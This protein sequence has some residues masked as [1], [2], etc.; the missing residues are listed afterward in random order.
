MQ[1]LACRVILLSTFW[2]TSILLSRA[3]ASV[4]V[5]HVFS[6]ETVVTAIRFYAEIKNGLHKCILIPSKILHNVCLVKS[7]SQ[8]SIPNSMLSFCYKYT[9]TYY[10]TEKMY[11]SL[12]WQYRWFI[13]SFDLLYA[14]S[15]LCFKCFLMF[16]YFR[17]RERQRGNKGG[18]EREGDTESQAGSRHWAISTE[19]KAGLK[20]TNE[21][22][23]RDL[24]WSQTLNQRSHPGA[25]MIWA[26][27]VNIHI[28]FLKS[29]I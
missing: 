23:D 10:K 13:F 7:C 1:L 21:R 19:P 14:L 28:L 29:K 24:S 27:L 25:P 18:A 12:R 26:F 15:F 9:H 8:I 4:C 11:I 5:L 16:I 17:E 2:G 6:L 20:L 3:A 22:W